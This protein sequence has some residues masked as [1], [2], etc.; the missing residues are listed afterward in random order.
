[1][2]SAPSQSPLAQRNPST[3]CEAQV[4]AGESFSASSA[5]PTAATASSAR[6]ASMNSP[7]KPNSL[8]SSRSAMARN[9]CRAASRSP[10]ELR[11]LRVQQQRQRIV[12]GMAA[13]DIGM[14]AGGGGI[15]V[16]DREQPVGDGVPAAGAAPFAPVAA[17]AF[18]QAPQCAQHRSTP[19][20]PRQWQRRAPA[21]IPA[22]WY[23][24]ASRSMT[25]RRRRSARPPTPHPRLRARSTAETE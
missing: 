8:V 10:V 18:R 5:I 2:A 6:W 12:R 13:R 20:S 7:R 16:A 19:A 11:R 25:A 15:A 21:R 24:R 4:D 23:G 9:A 3:A 22:A 1:M 17:E 14:H